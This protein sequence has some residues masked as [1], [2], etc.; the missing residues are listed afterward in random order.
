MKHIAFIIGISD[1]WANVSLTTDF[2]GT[3]Y[4]YTVAVAGNQQRPSVSMVLNFG[5]PHAAQRY[6]CD[7]SWHLIIDINT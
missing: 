1:T 3:V 5:T 6:T 7:L 2:N 4:S